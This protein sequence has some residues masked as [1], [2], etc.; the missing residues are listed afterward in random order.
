MS[1]IDARF[2][3]HWDDAESPSGTVNGTNVTFTLS[4]TPKDSAAVQVFVNGVYR[5][6]TTD[7][8]ISGTTLTFTAA[9]A[10]GSLVEVHYIK[11]T[12]ET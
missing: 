12:G 5:T 1:R 3:E 11:V 10:S 2:T 9:P 8:S 7:Y 4:Q 6:P